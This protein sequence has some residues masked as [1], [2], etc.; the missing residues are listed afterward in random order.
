VR[1]KNQEEATEGRI[2]EREQAMQG[3]PE[4]ARII[5][6]TD[7]ITMLN[8]LGIKQ[9]LNFTDEELMPIWKKTFKIG[10]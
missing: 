1:F 7:R 4:T 8:E 10:N 5:R 3:N 9:K 6:E 2:K